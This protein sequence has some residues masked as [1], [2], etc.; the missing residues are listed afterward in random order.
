MTVSQSLHTGFE[1]HSCG[2]AAVHIFV[3]ILQWYEC[4]TIQKVMTNY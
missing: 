4:D 3:W 1:I 2:L